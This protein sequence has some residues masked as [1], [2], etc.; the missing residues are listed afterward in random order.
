MKDYVDRVFNYCSSDGKTLNS[1]D[2]IVAFYCI[3][4]H[5]P[6]QTREYNYKEFLEFADIEIEREIFLEFDFNSK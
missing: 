3:F 6:S 5:R 2:F 4:G 1:N